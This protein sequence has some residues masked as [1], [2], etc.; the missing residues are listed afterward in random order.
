M[1]SA[2]MDLE[3]L[4]APVAGENPCGEWLR[5]EGIYDQV[6][7]ARREDDPALPQGVWQTELKRA[8]W[9]TVQTL[10]ATA[11]ATRSKDLQ[12]AVWLLEAW[13]QLDGFS[14]AAKGLTLLHGL[15]EC[16]W[17][18]LYPP[19]DADLTARLAPIRWINDKLSRR[20]RLLP[21]THPSI[22]GVPAYSLAHWDVAMRAPGNV[23]PGAGAVTLTK[24]EQSVSVTS[25]EWFCN[26]KDRVEATLAQI[27]ALDLLID[28]KAGRE[29]PGL[30]KLRSEAE[31]V[32]Q[33]VETMLAAARAR[34]PASPVE[35]A[36]EANGEF[37][38]DA[39]PSAPVH[40]ESSCSDDGQE[41]PSNLPATGRVRSRA[42]AYRLLE[43]I[44]EFLY[45]NDPHSPTPYLI[46]RA[47]AWGEMHFD[48]LLPELVRSDGGMN[49]M[50]KLFRVDR[51]D[52]H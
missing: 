25:Y 16:Y 21:L 51:S 24:F 2:S 19:L 6:R 35:T 37:D 26:L 42:E 48:E 34:L 8:D 43:E 33:L 14:G 38:S 10:C 4:L 20:L 15:S 11:L 45:H 31:A 7:E 30:V 12:L 3:I 32:E 47:V 52:G 13:I 50:I 36:P 22:Q 28:N 41:T 17:D 40:A 46:R 29:S 1:D 9:D 49:D 5:Y 44:A 39:A 23:D 18:G 27:R